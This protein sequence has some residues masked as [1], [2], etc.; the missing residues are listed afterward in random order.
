[1]KPT[2]PSLALLIFGALFLVLLDAATDP[3]PI[4][5]TIAVGWWI[6][7]WFVFQRARYL[8]EAGQNRAT[9]VLIIVAIVGLAV[10]VEAALEA[11]GLTE[12]PV[13]GYSYVLGAIAFVFFCL[14]ELWRAG[15]S[16][17]RASE[18]GRES[19]PPP[20]RTR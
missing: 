9:G 4:R 5:W 10:G 13:Y 8:R 1:M 12:L 19:E 20:H 16:T 14:A 15:G 11:S 3:S 6:W 17:S 2:R 7:A 18:E